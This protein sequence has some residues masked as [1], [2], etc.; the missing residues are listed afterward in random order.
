MRLLTLTIVV[1]GLAAG[2][3]APQA[4]AG[5]GGVEGLMARRGCLGG[6]GSHRC[7]CDYQ[8]YTVM[9]TMTRTV[10]DR[11]T[12]TC[13]KV[14]Y[15]TVWEQQ[16]VQDVRRVSHTHYRQEEFTYQRPTY[17]TLT[18][19]EPYTVCIPVREIQ[20]RDV[21]YTCYVPSYETRKRSIP[22]TT[23]RTVRE[24]GTRTISYCVPRTECY[25]KTIQ[26]PSGHWETRV[27]ECPGPVVQKCQQSPGCFDWD[28]CACRSLYKPGASQK[29]DVQCPPIKVCK[30]VWVPCV[31]ER[32]ITC[33]RTVYDTCTREV[34]YTRCHVVPETCTREVEYTVC[35]MV[36]VTNT[37]TVEYP[38]VRMTTEQ[39][40]RTVCQTV[41]HMI[42]EVGTR[43]VPYSTTEEIP[44]CR[45][46][47]VPRQVARTVCYNVTRCVPR[48]ECYQV[49]VRVC[50]PVPCD[51]KGKGKGCGDCDSEQ[52]KEGPAVPEPT[53]PEPAEA[54]PEPEQ[55]AGETGEGS[56]LQTV[57]HI[58]GTSA[59]SHAAAPFAA[60][61]EHY[62]GGRFEQAA[63]QFRMAAEIAADNATYGYYRAVAL[64][65]AGR[66]SEAQDSLTTA[67]AAERRLPIANWGVAMER[68][69]GSSRL[70]L[71]EARKNAG[72][73]E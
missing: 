49:P 58:P 64:H 68:V 19:E 67:V 55:S 71:E 24:T 38:V 29:V 60:G 5:Y 40:T 25:T 63:E 9:K 20:T 59:A 35:Q 57:S 3:F 61:L 51:P 50:C 14:V 10:Y 65:R 28:P 47:C 36:P 4:D 13:Q 44:V 34:P 46:V 12:D 56:R 27:V 39:R 33:H 15:D 16:T 26:V 66:E 53:E 30:R 7:G 43:C 48:T 1:L 52:P 22:Y 23:Y 69:Q 18:R 37:R 42:S 62:R 17:E 31:E 73:V 21:T 8:C 54:A 70:W 32:E 6:C 72:T 45:T 11:V 2:T 41:T